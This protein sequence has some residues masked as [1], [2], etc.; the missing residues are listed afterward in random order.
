MTEASPTVSL[1]S[2]SGQAA[3]LSVKLVKSAET[4][5]GEGPMEMTATAKADIDESNQQLIDAWTRFARRAAAGEVA[6]LPGVKVAFSRVSMPLL[7][8]FFFSSPV[9]DTAD[10][11][12]RVKALAAY[13][14]QSGFAWT[15]TVCHEWLLPM[16]VDETTRVL[17][18]VGLVPETHVIG[19]V[20]DTLLPP[21]R[22]AP[23]LEIRSIDD[24]ESRVDAA[25]LNMAAYAMPLAWGHEAFAREAFYGEGAFGCV[26]YA[27]REPAS[28]ATTILVNRGLYVALVA[29]AAPHR[30]KGYA[31]AVMRRSL[32][33]AQ[34]ESGF[35]RTALHATEAGFPVYQAMGYRAVADFTMY[36]RGHDG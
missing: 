12:R 20:T 33:L 13:G 1:N 5:H 30:K 14:D 22:A 21:R 25:D 24:P 16:G 26:G 6:D 27:L 2:G 34:S 32:A 36:G 19:M 29:T 31:E 15:L 3:L 18:S 10:L 4:G 17:S 7:N 8:A 28:T 35:T 11:D 23:A 9:A